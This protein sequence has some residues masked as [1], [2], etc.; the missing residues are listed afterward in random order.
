M[1]ALDESEGGDGSGIHAFNAPFYLFQ[2]NEFILSIFT[3]Y[4]QR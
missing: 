3:S 2:L 1:S 4:T